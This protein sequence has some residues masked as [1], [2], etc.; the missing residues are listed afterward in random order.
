MAEN[1]LT[2]ERVYA[3][4][5]ANI[6]ATDDISFKLLGIVP[7]LSGATLL[8]FFL[9]EHVAAEKAPL[10]ITLSLFA[11]LITLGLFRW[12]LRNIQT[13]SWLRRRAEALERCVVTSAVAPQQPQ[14]PL[15]IGKTE[16]EKWI[17]SVTI[18]AWL[19]LPAVVSR[20]ETWP[21]LLTLHIAVAAC[22]VVLT[23]LSAFWPVRVRPADPEGTRGILAPNAPTPNPGIAAD[24]NLTYARVHTAECRA[25]RHFTM[26][27]YDTRLDA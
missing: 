26:R 10:V 6:R 5:C 19:V 17:Y 7:L 13:C 23:L 20:L 15:S 11:A 14:P 1:V 9:K 16:A 12:E 8:T 25:V 27:S 4:T 24:V 22:V 2:T 21:R 3:E 18:I